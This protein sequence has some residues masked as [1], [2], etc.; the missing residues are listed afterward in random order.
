MHPALVNAYNILYGFTSDE[1]GIRHSQIKDSEVDQRLAQC[2]LTN[3][4]AFVTYL[5]S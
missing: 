4:S 3:C 1:E 2:F 5:Q